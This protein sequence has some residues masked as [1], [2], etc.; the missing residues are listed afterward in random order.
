MIKTNL[1]THSLY[2]DG[3]CSLEEMI[4]S[5]IEKEYKILGF[6][7]HAPVPFDNAFSIK[8]QDA[9]LDYVAE[10]KHLKKKYIQKIDIYLSLE[11]DYI[12]NLTTSFAEFKQKADLDYTIGAV[13]LV[14]SPSGALWFIDG[15]KHE[16][17]DNGLKNLFDNDIK[18]AVKTYYYQINEMLEKEN[19]DILAHFDKIKM[20]NQH[21]YFSEDDK[22]Y[23]NLVNESL[24]LIKETNTLLEVNTRGIYKKRCQDLFPDIPVLKQALAMNIPICVN[25]DAHHTED[26]DKALDIALQR[27]ALS[28]YKEV[29]YFKDKE[30]HGQGIE[31]N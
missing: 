5:A 1:H 26:F 14:K 27:V 12:P 29:F 15:G 13:H 3:K 11:I 10:I 17:Y 25:S 2:C 28:G 6:S 8:N 4:L 16:V 21:R 20:H 7:S 18:K 9:M 19:P 30:W 22:W 23:V 24:D 31:I